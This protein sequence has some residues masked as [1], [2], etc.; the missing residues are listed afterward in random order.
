MNNFIQKAKY[1]KQILLALYDAIVQYKEDDSR[2]TNCSLT[3]VNL[4][5]DYSQA[6]VYVDTN[7]SEP[8][9]INHL[10]NI[11]LSLKNYLAKNLPY[12][13]VPSLKFELDKSLSN[14]QKID[15]ILND[16][17]NKEKN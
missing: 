5:S 16:L 3:Q 15:Q 14:F 17:K 4:S 10:N 7:P 1:E 2:L 6:I 13:K 8:N 9:L 11:S 12:K